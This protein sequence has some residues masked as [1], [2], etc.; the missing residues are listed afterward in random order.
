[1]SE[2]HDPLEVLSFVT[3][4]LIAAGVR[5]DIAK[6]TGQ[7]LWE[8]S[9]RGT[10]S[11]GIRLLPHYVKGVQGGRI[12]PDP[13]MVFSTTAEACGVL[14]ADHGFGHAAGIEA[15]DSAI[16]LAAKPALVSRRY[17]T[18]LTAVPCPISLLEPQR[19]I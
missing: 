9:M 12:N 13:K 15:M 18:P 7:G 17:V 6:V 19:K 11:H 5:E 1:M 3:N 16:E 4:V 14:D 8:A 2:Q 10:D